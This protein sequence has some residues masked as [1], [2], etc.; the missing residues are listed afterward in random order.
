M[1]APLHSRAHEQQAQL[2]TRGVL[3]I[4]TLLSSLAGA[5][6]IAH[7]LD[8]LTS[9]SCSDAP[10]LRRSPHIRLVSL[11]VGR[12][13]TFTRLWEAAHR[14]WA[15]QHGY[16]VTLESSLEPPAAASPRKTLNWRKVLLLARALRSP[17]IDYALWLDSDIAVTDPDINVSAFL[18]GPRSK[19]IISPFLASLGGACPTCR[20]AAAEANTG[21]LL[22]RNTC[23]SRRFLSAWWHMADAHPALD[24]EATTSDQMAFNQL[25]MQHAADECP[26]LAPRAAACTQ[27]FAQPLL[28]PQEPE[29]F[30]C[31]GDY[32]AELDKSA[33]CAAK[34]LPMIHFVTE[35]ES[36]AA[37]CGLAT[38]LSAWRP[39]CFLVHAMGARGSAPQLLEPFLK[40]LLQHAPSDQ[41]RQSARGPTR[42]NRT[43]AAGR[44]CITACATLTA[45]WMNDS[46][47]L[48]LLQQ[49][50]SRMSQ[51]AERH[52]FLFH[53]VLHPPAR[54]H[55]NLNRVR[56]TLRLIQEAKGP[57]D[58]V[59]WLE[60]DTWITNMNMRP[61][62]FIK[63][64][65]MQ[66]LAAGRPRVE[67]IFSTDI[68]GGLNTG[69]GLIRR[70]RTASD[71]LRRVLTM[72]HNNASHPLIRQYDHQGA[73]ALLYDTEP[74]VR[75]Q[76]ALLDA[77]LLNPFPTPNCESCS[78]SKGVLCWNLGA[79]LDRKPPGLS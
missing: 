72:Q 22:V 60:A 67:M 3:A 33:G 56:L 19:H 31:V 51:Y 43:K 77:T 75:R 8:S 25:L 23:A 11:S 38:K 50:L 36:V 68:G 71:L 21:A 41:L 74:A 6:P 79:N 1:M 26:R 39:G 54:G 37:P 69:V 70:G 57:C 16:S 15:D 2:R 65:Q 24:V 42:L 53:P 76:I 63:E 5:D 44:V 55:C 40:K 34:Q 12:P 9:D 73:I 32:W 30:S 17:N 52:D 20:K 27:Y 7:E 28:R 14:R 45:K 4:A 66:Q 18:D 64:A 58:W 59:L 29:F 62:R 48:L 78:T 47:N 10:V 35:S 61:E 46:V 13:H 49:G